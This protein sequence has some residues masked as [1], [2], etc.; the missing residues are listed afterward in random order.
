M[1]TKRLAHC[2]CSVHAIKINEVLEKI[3]VIYM[4]VCIDEYHQPTHTSDYI[5]LYHLVW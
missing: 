1:G 3:V 2:C 5:D 4:Y